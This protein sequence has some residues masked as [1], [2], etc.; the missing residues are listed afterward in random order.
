MRAFAF[1]A[2]IALLVP[3][4][5]AAA[6]RSTGPA[7]APALPGPSGIGPSLGRASD[8]IRDGRR[9]GELSR[10]E[11][12]RARRER[13]QID[14]LADR[15]SADGYLSASERR[16]IETRAEVLRATVNAERLRGDTKRR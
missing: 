2:A 14:T 4:L 6:Q 15:Y 12:K 3:A 16:E 11:A 13:G 9:S 7:P 5:P 10:G 1:I 8:A